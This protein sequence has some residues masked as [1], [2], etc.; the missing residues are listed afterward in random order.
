[1]NVGTNDKKKV[2]F[3]IALALVAGYMVYANLFSGP[4]YPTAAKPAAGGRAAG[5]ASD[6]DTERAG[7]PAASGPDIRRANRNAKPKSEEFHPALHSKRKEDQIDVWTIDPTLHLDLLAK[8]QDMKPEGGQRNLFQFGPVQP[9]A[10]LDDKEPLVKPH[11]MGPMP[12][13]PKIETAKI[14]PLPPPI[15]FKY[16]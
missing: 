9:V 6:A 12:V 16:Y 8:V 15:P 7:A 3:L 2:G 1:M 14:E 13:T 10:R 11:P 5:V 4:S